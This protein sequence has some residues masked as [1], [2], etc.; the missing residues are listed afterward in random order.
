MG[1]IHLATGDYQAARSDLDKSLQIL[2]ELDS[3]HDAAQTK[4]AL[5]QLALQVG[6]PVDQEQLKEAINTFQKLG[7]Q[8]DLTKA[9]EIEDQIDSP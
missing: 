7:A 9:L 8:V 4:I 1:E 6:G 3:A 5:A 2:T